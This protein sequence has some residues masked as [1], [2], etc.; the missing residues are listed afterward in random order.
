MEISNKEFRSDMNERKKRQ[1]KKF[2]A[3]CDFR[4]TFF[5]SDSV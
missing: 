2:V 1:T 5:L 3:L 4:N